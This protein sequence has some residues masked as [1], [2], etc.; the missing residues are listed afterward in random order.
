MEKPD[1]FQI[2]LIPDEFLSAEALAAEGGA[3]RRRRSSLR[4]KIVAEQNKVH[5]VDE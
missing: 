4:D 5:P 2:G 1:W 3:K